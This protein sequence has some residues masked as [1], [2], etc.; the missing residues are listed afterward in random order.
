MSREILPAGLRGN[1]YR[2][3]RPGRSLGSSAFVSDAVVR[4][5]AKG[6]ARQLSGDGSLRA[7]ETI[8]YVCLLGRKH[9]GRREIADFYDARGPK[10]GEDL[11]T[12]AKP[13]WETY[14]NK[15]ADPELKFVVH[16]FPTVDGADLP[17]E[18]LRQIRHML[19]HLLA[20]GRTVLVG[21]SAAIG[22]TGEVL[23]GFA[24]PR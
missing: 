15:L 17:P 19:S 18:Q 13:A 3:A 24:V 20:Q 4:D 2:V 21:C 5:W 7:G 14:L 16:H 9:G 1:L 6:I 11:I 23:R 22:R 10:D 8:D 12:N